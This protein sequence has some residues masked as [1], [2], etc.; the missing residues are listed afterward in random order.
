MKRRIA[1]GWSGYFLM[2]LAISLYQSAPVAAQTG[3]R[4]TAGSP[5][6]SGNALTDKQIRDK[7][8][9]LL[10]QMTLEEKVAQLS[11]LPGMEVPEFKENVN[12]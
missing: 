6:A 11:Q 5:A 9:G 3:A 8:D 1:V 7:V 2:A 10:H 4:Q 12:K